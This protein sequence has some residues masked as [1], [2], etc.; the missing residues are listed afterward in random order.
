M[1]RF[2]LLIH[3]TYKIMKYQS[4]YFGFNMKS[5][6]L[7]KKIFFLHLLVWI[8]Y[9]SYRLSDFPN[10][11]GFERGLVYVSVPL[12]F[13]VVL[14][15]LHYFYLLPIWL[16]KK[17]GVRY[18]FSLLTLLIIGLGLQIIAES[19]AFEGFFPGDLNSANLSQSN[20]LGKYFPGWRNITPSRILRLLWNATIFILFTS[21][22]KIAIERFQLDSRRRQLENEKLISELNYL[23]AQIN[24]HFL[25]NTLHNLNSMVY[26]YSRNAAEVVVMLS[27]MMR[28]MI[29]DSANENVS[30]KDE[31]EYMKDYVHMESIR[32]NESFMMIFNVEGNVEQARIAPLILFPFLE[33]AFKHGVSD[34]TDGCWIK[35]EIL[36]TN[37][38]L[39]MRIS[40]QKIEPPQRR[41]K[42]G[43]GME[44]VKK[45]LALIY[46]NKHDLQIFESEDVFDVRLTLQ[47]E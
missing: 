47:I 35:T 23:K 22:I 5:L 6:I 25:F 8:F 33:N 11:L 21:M 32:L 45:R 27:N 9:L 15:Y 12:V 14:S 19:K 34:Q 43:F 16:E 13:Y 46:P 42:S 26:P 39:K 40:N 36:V 2:D 20:L 1:D 4:P 37:E 28:Y 29:Y 24:P 41:E 7:D 10:F 17:Q 44:N 30:L 18:L 3:R 38:Q 31:I